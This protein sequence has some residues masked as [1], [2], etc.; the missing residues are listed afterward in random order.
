[1]DELAKSKLDI[2]MSENQ[3]GSIKRDL[4]S[5]IT[6]LNSDENQNYRFAEFVL[7]YMPLWY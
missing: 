5:L 7:K 3:T 6:R 4:F 2:K 1:V